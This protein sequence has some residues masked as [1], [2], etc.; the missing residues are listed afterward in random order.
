MQDR[1]AWTTRWP[2]CRSIA[3]RWRGCWRRRTSS[4]VGTYF[5]AL[6]PGFQPPPHRRRRRTRSHPGPGA[7]AEDGGGRGERPGRRQQTERAQLLLE[8]DRERDKAALDAWTKTWVAAAQ[9]GTPAPSLDEFKA[10][11]ASRVTPAVQLLGDLPTPSSPQ[12]PATS[13]GAPPTAPMGPQ[14][15]PGMPP[16]PMLPHGAPPR[17]APA[18]PGGPPRIRRRRWRCR[19]RCGD[20]GCR[21]RMGS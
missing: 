2:A 6:P 15:V 21:G 12:P 1:R 4:D 20:A 10:A 11:M 8:D 13:P 14:G 7:A 19:G 3:T 16:R 9:F 17:R 5:K 18:W